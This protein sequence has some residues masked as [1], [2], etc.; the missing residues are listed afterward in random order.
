M[1]TEQK[2]AVSKW[3]EELLGAFTPVVNKTEEGLQVVKDISEFFKARAKLEEEYAKKLST[4]YKTPPGT[5]FFTKETAISKEHK[6]LKEALLGMLDKGVKSSEAHQEFA[7]KLNTDICKNLDNWIKNKTIDRQKVITDGQKHIK[8]ANDAKVNVARAKAEYE[9]LMKEADTAKEQ[10]L[11]AEKDESSQPD[12]KK[13]PPITKKAA[14]K[15]SLS[16]TKSKAQEVVYQNLVTKT[17][18]ELESHRVEKMPVIHE[19]LQKWEEDRWN[20]LLNS[21]KMYKLLQ[22]VVPQILDQQAKDLVSNYETADIEA[23]FRDFINAN[24]KDEISLTDENVEFIPFK[25]RYP[26]DEEVLAPVAEEPKKVEPKKEEPKKEEP[27][28]VEEKVEVNAKTQEQN[29]QEEV[30]KEAEKKKTDELKANLFG[31]DSDMF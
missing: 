20:T 30:K 27:K 25:S 12:N 29:K 24:K 16:R 31:N 10:L 17:N 26:D 28:K 7:N 4:L 14:E 15:L 5:G 6:T 2:T 11:K 9:R 3:S 21:V 23:D 18:E 22:E 19:A 13:L 1:K 8:G